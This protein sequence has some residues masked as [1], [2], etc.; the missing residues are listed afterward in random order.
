MFSYFLLPPP[1]FFFISFSQPLPLPSYPPLSLS[2]HSFHT[3]SYYSP[4]PPPL[5]LHTLSTLIS[6]LLLPLSH[7]SSPRAASSPNT[8]SIS[9]IL[10]TP[11][12]SPAPPKWTGQGSF[13]TTSY[14]YF[15]MGRRSTMRISRVTGRDDGVGWVDAMGGGGK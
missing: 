7:P 13:S 4:P 11:R 9:I 2:F 8:P 12:C 15:L 14:F 10:T 5:S 3:L 1:A 6:F